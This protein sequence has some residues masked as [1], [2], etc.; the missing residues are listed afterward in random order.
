MTI[1]TKFLTTLTLILVGG[2]SSGGDSP[3]VIRAI[4]LTPESLSLA[5][6]A[7]SADYTVKLQVLPPQ[8]ESIVVSVVS[9]D[10]TVAVVNP[11]SLTFTSEDWNTAQTVSVTTVDDKMVNVPDRTVEITHAATGAGYDEITLGSLV[12]TATDDDTRGMTVSQSSRVLEEGGS[13]TYTVA[14][15]SAPTGNVT[16]HMTSSSTDV[17]TVTGSL[18]FTPTSW[19]VAQTV[20]LRGT[21]NTNSVPTGATATIGH[22]VTGG[23]YEGVIGRNVAVRVLDDDSKAVTVSE[24]ALT[25]AE[26][27]GEGTYTVVLGSRPTGNVTVSVVS[28]TQSAVTVSSTSLVFTTDNWNTLQT[29]TV[30]GVNDAIDN[31][32]DRT[33]SITHG[34]AGGNYTGVPVPSVVTVTATDDDVRG[35]QLSRGDFAVGE[36]YA[37]PIAYTVRLKSQPTH[38]VNVR[39]VS[40]NTDALGVGVVGAD[41]TGLLT[42]TTANWFTP[43][44]LVVIG[45]DDDV[46]QAPGADKT[47]VVTHTAS[48]GD[49]QGVSVSITITATDNESSRHLFSRNSLAETLPS[50]LPFSPGQ[51]PGLSL[52]LDANRHKASLSLDRGSWP[53]LSDILVAQGGRESGELLAVIGRE[54]EV[55]LLSFIYP[56]SVSVKESSRDLGELKEVMIY[57]EVL[58]EDERAKLQ[59]YLSCRWQL[60]VVS[61]ECL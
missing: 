57:E 43:Q 8:G 17:V 19:E 33:S 47:S 40:G 59:R 39:V 14:L 32:P 49:Y 31:T 1:L 48:G 25:V 9:A 20:T 4:I 53:G 5:E 29:V 13:A 44:V 26:N 51:I 30:R 22:V 36:L 37:G 28:S 38:S 45:S 27:S 58:E 56:Y 60:P 50:F 24:T 11:P 34:V 10:L 12:V 3:E 35:I 6:E 21:Q 16:V 61:G 41:D 2:C 52:W 18:N 15:T 46:N 7:Q 42:F 54:G 55:D 23:D